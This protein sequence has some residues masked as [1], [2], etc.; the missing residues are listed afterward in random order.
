M[1]SKSNAANPRMLTK[2]RSTNHKRIALLNKKQ[3]KY[4]NDKCAARS[5]TISSM[6][7]WSD[8]PLFDLAKTLKLKADWQ[9]GETRPRAKRHA[10]MSQE[11]SKR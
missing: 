1:H 6:E 10:W 3:S 2:C 5:S 11:G 9:A 4:Q 7:Y 8:G